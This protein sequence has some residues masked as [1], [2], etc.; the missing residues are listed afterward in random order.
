MVPQKVTTSLRWSELEEGSSL[1]S[2]NWISLSIRPTSSSDTMFGNIVAKL[3][4]ADADVELIVSGLR[5]FRHFKT[6]S[7]IGNLCFICLAAKIVEHVEE[8]ILIPL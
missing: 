1:G 6:L 2:M 3:T 8:R 4:T 5:M 7:S